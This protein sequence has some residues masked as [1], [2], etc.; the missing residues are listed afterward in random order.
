MSVL[1]FFFNVCRNCKTP[2]YYQE[3]HMDE[4]SGGN[5]EGK[6]MNVSI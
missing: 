2:Q 4:F 1:V 3:I 6:S 5:N